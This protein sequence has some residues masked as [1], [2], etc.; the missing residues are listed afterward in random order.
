[1]QR[2][3]LDW[4][5]QDDD[6]D[7]PMLED[8]LSLPEFQWVPTPKMEFN[9]VEYFLTVAKM[10]PRGKAMLQLLWDYCLRRAKSNQNLVFLS[11]IAA[12]LPTLLDSNLPPSKTAQLALLEIH[13]MSP[14]AARLPT[15]LDL[16]PSMM[17]TLALR[18]MTFFPVLVRS[19]IMERHALIH[20][21]EFRFAFWNPNPR[22]LYECKEPI[23]QLES[24]GKRAPVIDSRNNAFQEEIFAATFNMIWTDKSGPDSLKAT[25]DPAGVSPSIFY[26]IQMSPF[27][28]LYKLNP[29]L[30]RHVKCHKFPLNTLDNPAISALILY[31]WSTLGFYVWLVRFALQCLFYILVIVTVF[32]QVYIPDHGSL[33]ILYGIIMALS[34]SFLVLEGGNYDPIGDEF[35]GQ[36]WAF[37]TVM[38]IYLFFTVI[39]M[40]NVLIALIN[41]GYDEGDTTWQL[42]WL[43]NRL[44]YIESAENMPHYIPGLRDKY[45]IF[46]QEIYYSLPKTKVQGYKKLW[47]KAD[48]SPAGAEADDER[49]RTNKNDSADAKDGRSFPSKKDQ[50]EVLLTQ[51]LVKLAFMEKKMDQSVKIKKNGPSY[52]LNR[53]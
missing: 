52:T 15:F 39:V 1:M 13:S 2:L 44:W 45:D 46:P 27:V 28:A 50:N 38:I 53:K 5:I 6:D 20:P 11:P 25:S 26:W 40:L 37:H 35:A 30:H 19:V 48:N 3:C 41:S 47:G 42:F 31:K 49:D 24:S 9:P 8:I 21:P 32:V 17:A 12:C 34:S 14:I 7:S 23:F 29:W 33:M 43:K 16:P 51:I 22:P 10:V 18:E 4:F 36:N